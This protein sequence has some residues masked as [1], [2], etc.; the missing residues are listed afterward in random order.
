MKL[1][2]VSGSPRNGNTEWMLNYLHKVLSAKGVETELLLLRKLDVQMC[3]GCLAC[4]AGDKKRKGI[5]S[6]KDD[7]QAI[8]PK[9]LEADLIIF[10]TP[11]Y[12]EMLSGLLKN[13]M[14]RTCAVWPGLQGKNFAGIIVAEESFGK[15]VDN[16]K[17]YASVCGMNWSGHVAALA[18]NPR[19]VANDKSVIS[20]LEKLA[21]KLIEQTAEY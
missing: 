10:G 18:K 15:T 3:N 8:Y 2:S 20:K 12:F 13:F 7:M 6:I 16:L 11:V 17:T 1:V 5:C 4:E 14:D 21:A 19:Q 9:L